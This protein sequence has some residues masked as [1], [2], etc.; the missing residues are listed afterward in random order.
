MK[1][2]TTRTRPTTRMAAA[3]IRAADLKA[4]DGALRSVLAG[5]Q[6]CY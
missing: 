3:L 2:K 1:R 4:E 5:M 6:G